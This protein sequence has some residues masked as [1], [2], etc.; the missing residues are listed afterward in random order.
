MLTSLLIALGILAIFILLGLQLARCIAPKAD[1]LLLA[2][3]AFPLGAGIYTWCVFCLALLGCPRQRTAG[4]RGRRAAG[5]V[6]IVPPRQADVGP[7]RGQPGR[8]LGRRR[9][10]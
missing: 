6:R 2:G 10:A 9:D 3:V 4:V 5:R 1:H 8:G 7:G